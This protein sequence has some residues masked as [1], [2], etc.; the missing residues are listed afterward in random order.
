MASLKPINVGTSKRLE[1]LYSGYKGK[2]TGKSKPNGRESAPGFFNQSSLNYSS[3][4]LNVDPSK[5]YK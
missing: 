5:R 2:V 3:A 1:G 4:V